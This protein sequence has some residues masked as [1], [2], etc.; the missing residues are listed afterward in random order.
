MTTIQV[1]TELSLTTLLNSLKQLTP[2]E[3]NE[4]AKY[5]A[6]LRARRLAP[7]LSQE[8][9][10]LLLKINQG[11]VPSEIRTRCATLTKKSRQGIITERE[12][13]ELMDLVDQIE[14]LNA[15]RMEYLVQLAHLRQTTLPALMDDLELKPLSYE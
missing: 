7:S 5:S 11:V 12:H 3:L 2:N 13:A 10:E 4:V 8:E 6:L 14:L 15:K 9:A 1:Q